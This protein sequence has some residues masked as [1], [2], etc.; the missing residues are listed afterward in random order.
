MGFGWK[1]KYTEKRFL[2][3]DVHTTEPGTGINP[4]G[5]NFSQN[6]GGRKDYEWNIGFFVEK[7]WCSK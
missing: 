2:L 4:P 1:P 7:S 3:S 6:F 5:L